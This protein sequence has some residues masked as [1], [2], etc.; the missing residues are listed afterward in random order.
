MITGLTIGIFKS[1]CE[2][3]LN[4]KKMSVVNFTGFSC[5]LSP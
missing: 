4:F 5:L 2:V 3:R 1:M